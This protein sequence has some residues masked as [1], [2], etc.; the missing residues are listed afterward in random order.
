MRAIIKG[1]VVIVVLAVTAIGA[2]ADPDPA[3]PPDRR[4]VYR[5]L[6][7]SSLAVTVIGAGVT[8]YT[9]WAVDD[10]TEDKDR[11]VMEWQAATSMQLD[12]LDACSDADARLD[13]GS[14]PEPEL[15]GHVDS[16]CRRGQRAETLSYVAIPVTLVGAVTAGVFYY[17]GYIA[18][19]PTAATM[20]LAPRRD[21][22][23]AVHLSGR[24]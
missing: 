16:A 4:G 6:F 1:I 7:W 3:A 24:F 13:G 18:G 17:K 21:G 9:Y 20:S 19:R 22:G 15:L 14:P 2:R 12:L 11:A 10:A 8:G 23:L 5:T